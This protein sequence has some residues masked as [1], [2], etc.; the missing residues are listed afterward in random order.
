VPE[1]ETSD[2]TSHQIANPNDVV[3]LSLGAIPWTE[4]T[5]GFKLL[6]RLAQPHEDGDDEGIEITAPRKFATAQDAMAMATKAVQWFERTGSLP[7]LDQETLYVDQLPDWAPGRRPAIV[8][9]FPPG[10]GKY[11]IIENQRGGRVVLNGDPEDDFFVIKLKDRNA[12]GA[13]EAYAASARDSGQM[14]LA[15]YVE[16]L[17]ARSGDA[18]P[19]CKSPD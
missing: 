11:S 3:V 5:Y 4:G 19:S 18:H 10:P 16:S 9:P 1:A 14:A 2:R 13:L 15:T 17:A 7:P 12:P 8:E 6:A